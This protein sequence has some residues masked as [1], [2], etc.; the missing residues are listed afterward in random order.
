MS[1]RSAGLTAASALIQSAAIASARGKALPL[2]RPTNDFG[3][4]IRKNAKIIIVAITEVVIVL[5]SILA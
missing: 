1:S 4:K 2:L 3:S 5:R